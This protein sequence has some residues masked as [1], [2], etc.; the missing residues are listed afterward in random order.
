MLNFAR[1]RKGLKACQHDLMF[2]SIFKSIVG[3]YKSSVQLQII[4]KPSLPSQTYVLDVVFFNIPL[5][6]I[7]YHSA[8]P[9]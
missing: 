6:C 1:L 8:T 2:I 9:G 3:I 7:L 4:R 5:E